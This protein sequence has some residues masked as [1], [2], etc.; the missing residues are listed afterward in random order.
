MKNKSNIYDKHL[1]D[2]LNNNYYNYGA[3]II[4]LRIP[5]RRNKQN[6]FFTCLPW[7]RLS[8]RPLGSLCATW[9]SLFTQDIP[10]CD[11]SCSIQYLLHDSSLSHRYT[12][13]CWVLPNPQNP[14]F[15]TH[16]SLLL[17]YHTHS[18]YF[19]TIHTHYQ[20]PHTQ[21][22]F[23]YHTHTLPHTHTAYYY[24]ITTQGAATR[25]LPLCSLTWAACGTAAPLSFSAP[26]L[27]GWSA[28]PRAPPGCRR[29]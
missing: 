3:H 5:C 6:L 2:T 8:R 7:I 25:P 16:S 20:L 28:P 21:Q 26:S 14:S 29:T 24:S 19:I 18:S 27:A 23:H 15:H 4:G 1:K 13:V 22:L 17:H 12:R 11:S 9:S 10:R